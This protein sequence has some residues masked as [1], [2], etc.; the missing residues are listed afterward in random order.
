MRPFAGRGGATGV[1]G[2]VDADGIGI[3]ED[4]VGARIMSSMA[5]E[6]GS[7]WRFLG[8]AA[9][10]TVDAERGLAKWVGLRGRDRWRRESI[11]EAVHGVG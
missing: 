10:R 1:V 4:F 5:S 8:L 2:T 9:W 6:L 11:F 7:E 3:G